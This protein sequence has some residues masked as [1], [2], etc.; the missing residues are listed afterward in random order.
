LFSRLTEGIGTPYL[1]TEGN[2]T[3]ELVPGPPKEKECIIVI[4]V[5]L[6]MKRSATG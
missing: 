5:H 1:T 6:F 3:N 4:I 2:K